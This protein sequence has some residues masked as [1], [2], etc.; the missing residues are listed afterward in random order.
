MAASEWRALNGVKVFPLGRKFIHGLSLANHA[1]P[2]TSTARSNSISPLK[3]GFWSDH[4]RRSAS[5]F[6][7]ATTLGGSGNV[8][9]DRAALLMAIRG[10]AAAFAL[11]YRCGWPTPRSWHWQ[12]GAQMGDDLMAMRTV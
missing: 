4:R 7:V 3:P 1:L 5:A 8:Y 12:A 9:P 11:A 10:L 6:S 2:N